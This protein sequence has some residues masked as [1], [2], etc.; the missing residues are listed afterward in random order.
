MIALIILVTVHGENE[1]FN[2]SQGAEE[3][4]AKGARVGN[5]S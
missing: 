2:E 3:R 1:H 5:S 4:K